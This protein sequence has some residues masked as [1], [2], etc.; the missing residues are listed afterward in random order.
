MKRKPCI[1]ER[2]TETEGWGGGTENIIP[3]R[4]FCICIKDPLEHTPRNMYLKFV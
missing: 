4:Y 1:R 2:E 3:N